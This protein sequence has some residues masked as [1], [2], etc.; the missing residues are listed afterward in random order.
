[1][2]KTET[3]S[4]DDDD[5]QMRMLLEAADPTLL[6][7]DMFKKPKTQ[8]QPSTTIQLDSTEMGT[9]R[10]MPKTE[11]YLDE[12]SVAAASDL[13][14]SNE[15]QTHIWGKLSAIIQNQIEFCEPKQQI[16]CESQEKQLTWTNQVKL[17]ANADCYIVDTIEEEALPRKKP[18]IK[19]RLPD[20][21][22]PLTRAV[23]VAAVAV[24]GES[25]LNGKDMKYWAETRKSRKDK[26]YKY[27]AGVGRGNILTLIEDR[28]DP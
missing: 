7:N 10:K 15:M 14:V 8:T 20:E 11:R 16:H 4:D 12:Q 1:M 27:K 26:L 19:R 24:S 17:V 25:I 22:K 6:T 23:A 3:D 2:T 18:T 5:L 13:Q 9:A 28:R 21:E